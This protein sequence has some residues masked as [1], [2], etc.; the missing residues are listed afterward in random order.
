ME[1]R[2]ILVFA[3]IGL[4]GCAEHEDCADV[5]GGSPDAGAGDCDTEEDPGRAADEALE[6]AHI[7][8]H[9]FP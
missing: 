3:L 2:T 5:D 9:L 4:S 8:E 6:P 1:L 7:F